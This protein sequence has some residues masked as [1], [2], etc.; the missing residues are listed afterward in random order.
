M[1]RFLLGI[2]VAAAA[3]AAAAR[4]DASAWIAPEEGQEILTTALG[5]RDGVTL[6]ESSAYWEAPVSPNASLVIAPWSETAADL[7]SGW[8]GEAVVGVKRAVFRDDETVFAVQAGAFWRSDP[9]ADCGEGGVEVRGL[10][11]RSLGATGFVNV[12]LAGRVL[13]EGCPTG[14]LSLS[15]GFRPRENWLALGEVF[16]ESPREGSESLKFQLSLVRFGD[17]GRGVQLGVRTSLDGGGET[18]FVLGLWGRPGG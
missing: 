7:Q 3:A 17:D 2:G 10:A 9:P 4:A 11:G 1:G 18:A 5:A 14:R 16:F 8:R 15:A 12:E 6:L 13:D